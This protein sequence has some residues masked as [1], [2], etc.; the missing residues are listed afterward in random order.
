MNSS[1]VSVAS[2]SRTSVYDDDARD[3]GILAA[4]SVDATTSTPRQKADLAL[5]ECSPPAPQRIPKAPEYIPSVPECSPKVPEPSLTV[6]ECNPRA[7]AAAC[8]LEEAKVQLESLKKEAETLS[9]QQAKLGI[10]GIRRLCFV[11]DQIPTAERNLADAQARFNRVNS[12]SVRV[13][14]RISFFGS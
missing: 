3:S 5:P 10:V 8:E 7:A 14:Q 13:S 12:G 4:F 11:R 1:S 9:S 6:P 2:T